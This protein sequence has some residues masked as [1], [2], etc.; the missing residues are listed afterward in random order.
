[1]NKKGKKKGVKIREHMHCQQ[2]A[3]MASEPKTT[4]LL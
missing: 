4:L 1:M 2:K 3:Q